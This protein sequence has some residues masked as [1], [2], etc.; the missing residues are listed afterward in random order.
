VRPA[1]DAPGMGTPR[2]AGYDDGPSSELE[3]AAVEE[4]AQLVCEPVHVLLD[5]PPCS[6]MLDHNACIKHFDFKAFEP[7]EPL[8]LPGKP[9][10]HLAS[11][12]PAKA[13]VELEPCGITNIG[14]RLFVQRPDRK[15]GTMVVSNSGKPGG[16]CALQAGSNEARTHR[17]GSVDDE[18]VVWEQLNADHAEHEEDLVS[19]WLMTAASN[20]GA[21]IKGGAYVSSVF[22]RTAH[23]E[24]GLL[25]P[26]GTNP[27][28]EYM[29][30]QRVNYTE[31]GLP[32]SSY[33][34]AWVIEDVQL[35][36]KVRTK[37]PTREL[38]ARFDSSQQ[39]PTALVF[40]AGPNVASPT[41]GDCTPASASRR[42]FNQACGACH[43]L[44]A[45]PPP[46]LSSCSRTL[47]RP[48]VAAV[49]HV[50]CVRRAF[51]AIARPFGIN[52]IA[53][54][55]RG[56]QDVHTAQDCANCR[57][58]SRSRHSSVDFI[59]AVRGRERRWTTQRSVR[60]S[61][62]LYVQASSQWRCAVAISH[63]SESSRA[64]GSRANGT[65]V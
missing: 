8:P 14:R 6:C 26:T 56:C 28:C 47:P 22:S 23:G 46:F 16:A 43:A 3:Q 29:T 24:W 32:P 10:A 11:R 51:D 42:T 25:D 35:S 63:C 40:V 64:A 19:N 52:V 1:A 54:H 17:A 65:A 30:A 21:A 39:Y 44:R 4:E 41:D 13:I 60:A 45:L 15:L 5:P 48:D 34:D 55:R 33:A 61:R 12:R 20:A 58:T 50:A 31:E 57:P 27:I 18:P 62:Q 7:G 49:A 9:P 37:L 36:I 38:P 2:S 53:P 59:R